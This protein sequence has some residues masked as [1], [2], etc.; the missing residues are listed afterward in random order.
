MGSAVHLLAYIRPANP[1]PPEPEEPWGLACAEDEIIGDWTEE[2]EAVT[3]G[4]CKR[5]KVYREALER[6]EG[7]G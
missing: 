6:E 5:T 3:C 7:E 2:A 4:N 1:W